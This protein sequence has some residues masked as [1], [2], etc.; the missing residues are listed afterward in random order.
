MRSF[1]VPCRLG[2]IGCL[3][4]FL[5]GGGCLVGVFVGEVAPGCLGGREEEE[6]KE[7]KGN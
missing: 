3:A 1:Q 2:A 5:A 6:A 7:P 4:L